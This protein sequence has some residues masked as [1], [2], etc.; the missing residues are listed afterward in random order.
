MAS[1]VAMR[2]APG[3]WVMLTMTAGW[4]LN[5]PRE[6]VFCTPSLT[7]ATSDRRTSRP[8][9]TATMRGR[10]SLAFSPGAG[11]MICSA[12]PLLASPVCST[13][14]GRL[15]LLAWMAART[16]SAAMPSASSAKG[17]SCTRT[18]GSELPPSST[19]PTPGTC[20]RRW[21][22]RLLTRSYT[23]PGERWVDESARIMK[24]CEAGL[25]LRQV[26]MAGRLAGRSARAA[27]MAACTSRAA[28]S[29]SRD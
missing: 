25:R 14:L 29:M 12:R 2:L 16:S 9:R 11:V 4:P 21:L 7:W 22:T 28:L 3:C 20:S 24:G 26:G 19:S 13:P 5:R 6:R 27:L 8:L 15:A 17:L 23:C 1:A 10:Q 18:A